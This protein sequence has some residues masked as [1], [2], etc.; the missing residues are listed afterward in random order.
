MPMCVVVIYYNEVTEEV[1]KCNKKATWQ[2]DNGGF[3]C[4]EHRDFIINPELLD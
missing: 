2:G 4:D 1:E 3:A